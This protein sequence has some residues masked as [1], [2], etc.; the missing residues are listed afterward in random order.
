MA[1]RR[2]RSFLNPSGTALSRP[3]SSSSPVLDSEPTP[4]RRASSRTLLT[5]WCISSALVSGSGLS[6][7]CS[8]AIAV[9]KN[10]LPA[11][12]RSRSVRNAFRRDDGAGGAF[13]PELGLD[14]LQFV[15]PRADKISPMADRERRDLVRRRKAGELELRPFVGLGAAGDRDTAF[16]KITVRK[17]LDCLPDSGHMGFGHFIQAVKQHEGQA[18]SQQFNKLVCRISAK[19]VAKKLHDVIRGPFLAGIEDGGEFTE[20]DAQRRQLLM[21]Q[22]FRNWQLRQMRRQALANANRVGE[23][24]RD[25]LQK[26]GFAR[27]RLT[28][29]DNPR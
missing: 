8:A 14:G 21:A 28:H 6:G 2:N 27:T 3:A 29:E 4:R 22:L 20:Q 19:L 10:G 16:P 11:I 12:S 15:V 18:T 5:S 25:V 1:S 26:R 7:R 13:A 24:E 17:R 9:R 23:T